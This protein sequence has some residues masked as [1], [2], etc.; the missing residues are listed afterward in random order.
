[1]AAEIE[2][3][4]HGRDLLVMGV[5]K[6]AFVFCADLVRL[7]DLPLV[8]DF[9]GLSSY[10]QGRETSGSIRVTHLPSC[11]IK[12]KDVLV[13]EDIVDTGLTTTFLL[14]YLNKLEPASIKLCTLTDKPSRRQVPVAVDY[15]GFTVPERF[16]VGYGIDYGERFRNLKDIC[17]V[18]ED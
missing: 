14:D 11:S 2:K 13:V 4:Y 7:I 5:L 18:E 17:Y 10:H 8:V 12:G 15:L 16:I 3:D 1:M 9:I 6:G